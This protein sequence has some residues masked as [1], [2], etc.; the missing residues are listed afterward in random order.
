MNGVIARI[1][2]GEKLRYSPRIGRGSRKIDTI[3]IN[4]VELYTIG[5]VS[6][7]G[8]FYLM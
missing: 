1:P 4:S 3:S 5:R 7:G 8:I 2:R 6:I